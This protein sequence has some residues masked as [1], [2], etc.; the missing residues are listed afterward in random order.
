MNSV[1]LA[2]RELGERLNSKLHDGLSASE[3]CAIHERWAKSKDNKIELSDGR[4]VRMSIGFAYL[5][6]IE[7]T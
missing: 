3:F 5:Y 7:E 2:K 6:L 1:E 4:I